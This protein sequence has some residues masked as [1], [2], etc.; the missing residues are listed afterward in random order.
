[1]VPQ[2]LS[3]PA[4]QATW[5]FVKPNHNPAHMAAIKLQSDGGINLCY[6]H[7]DQ[8][9]APARITDTAGTTVRQWQH[10]AFGVG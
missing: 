10:Y 8:L 7:T 1:M 4:A 6:I 5:G 9:G 3:A 2:V